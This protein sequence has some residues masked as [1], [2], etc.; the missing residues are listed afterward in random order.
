MIS[1]DYCIV[2]FAK[3]HSF[4]K[5]LTRLEQQCQ[6]LNIPFLGFTEYP[7]GCPSHQ[8]SPFAFKFFCIDKALQQGYSKILWLDSSVF[9][10]RPIDDIFD[11]IDKKGYFFLYNH[12]LGSFCHDKALSTLGI[13]REESFRMPCMQGTNFGLNFNNQ[14]VKLFFYKIMELA[15][16]KITFPGPHNNNDFRA[17]KDPRVKGHRHDQTAMSVIALRYGLNEWITTGETPWFIHEREFVK[18]VESTVEEVN[19]S[20]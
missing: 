3:G 8:E 7:E 15:V 16:D 17:S 1:K 2:T 11:Y 9:I 13:T 14:D 4:I 18:S 19:M 6:E 10:K 20:E 12:D 5:G